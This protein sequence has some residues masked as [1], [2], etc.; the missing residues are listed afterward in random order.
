M[1]EENN[2]S[3]SSPGGQDPN[4]KMENLSADDMRQSEV[5]LKSPGQRKLIIGIVIAGIIALI[6]VAMTAAP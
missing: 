5:V 4:E 6:V 3:G 2:K 1:S